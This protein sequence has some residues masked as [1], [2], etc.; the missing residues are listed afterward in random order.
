MQQRPLKLRAIIFAMWIGLVAF[1]LSLFAMADFQ[2]DS[3]TFMNA[4]IIA[5][6]CGVLS[7]GAAD[8]MIEMVTESL[9][10]AIHRM[11]AAAKGDLQSPVPMQV[12]DA[13]PNLTESLN[14]LFAEVRTS[15][16]S[17]NSMALFDP[18]TALANRL[19]FRQETIAILD[20]LGPR[21]KAAL[22]FIDLDN[23]KSVN[24]NLG[25]AAGDQLL[26]MVANRLRA[27]VASL[28]ARTDAGRP[29]PV[30]GRLAGDEFTVF[31]PDN[32]SE[33]A[34][35][36]I[37][38]TIVD[39]LSEPFSIAG[40]LVQIGG[41]VGIALRPE[42]GATLTDLMRAA[43]VAMYDAKQGGRGRFC[44]YTDA[45][46][47]QLASKVKLDTELRAG[48]D[49]GEFGFEFQPQV[50]LSDNSIAS[51]EALVR[52][53]HPTEGV[54]TPGSFLRAAEE[55]GLIVEI[56]DW[57][58]DATAQ[59]IASWQKDGV[60]HRLSANLSARQ[61][62]RGSLFATAQRTFEHHGASMALLELELAEQLIMESG[63]ALL[64][65]LE[66]FRN[67]GATVVIDNFGTGFS[68]IARLRSL[69]FDRVKLDRSL[70]RNI[71]QD[72]TARNILHSVVALVHSV[73]REAVAE[74][75]E[76]Q[77]QLDVLKVIGC[78][79]AQGFAIAKPMREDQL[80]NWSAVTRLSAMRQKAG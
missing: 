42:H 37:G 34:A 24:D 59:T 16:E 47:E 23:F 56:G 62:E 68:N 72:P 35:R 1:V 6:C 41:S 71:D 61:F 80:K 36:K 29:A 19:H 49:N 39:A 8:R 63:D 66:A 22:L 9:N 74:G 43:D 75:V 30:V 20:S 11:A 10:I 78:D 7:W 51:A 79:A 55:S 13:L 45:L 15:I 44:F 77:A 76:S 3:K 65:D 70:T 4:G 21:H 69:P 18:V 50:R 64:R 2:V 32:K 46:A 26:I 14:S 17:A 25:H 28:A 58:M 52:W 48:L 33:A 73:G 53:N 5:A 57:A 40:S 38:K 67:A 31:I 12:D 27:I 60:T 54:R